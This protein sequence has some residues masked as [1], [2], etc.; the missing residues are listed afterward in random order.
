[1]IFAYLLTHKKVKRILV[2]VPTVG[3]VLQTSGDY[4]GV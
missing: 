2:V 1:M 4:E 3:L